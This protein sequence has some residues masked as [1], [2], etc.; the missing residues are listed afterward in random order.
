MISFLQNKILLFSGILLLTLFAVFSPAVSHSA[1][2]Q[3]YSEC[4]NNVIPGKIEYALCGEGATLKAAADACAAKGCTGLQF[5]CL[6]SSAGSCPTPPVDPTATLTKAAGG[7]VVQYVLPSVIKALIGIIQFL[8]SVL[9]WVVGIV[10]RLFDQAVAIALAGF[11]QLKFIELGWTIAR[12]VANI[13]FILILLVIAIATILR[14]ET[15]GIKQLLPRLVITALLINFSLVISFAVVDASNLLALQFIEPI[16][17]VS[18]KI[19]DV[20]NI[21]QIT[22]LNAGTSPRTEI[23]F[24][25]AVTNGFYDVLNKYNNSPVAN[26]SAATAMALGQAPNQFDPLIVDGLFQVIILILLLILIF[27]FIALGA[28]LIIRTIALMVIF[29]FAPIGFIAGILPQTKGYSTDWWRALFNWSFFFPASAF[30]MYLAIQYGKEISAIVRDSQ[31]LNT[32]ALFSYVSIAAI[33]LGS[34]LVA[35]KMGIYG[36]D[37]AINIGRKIQKSAQGYAGRGTK[38]LG[39]RA[40]GGVAQSVTKG[41]SSIPV[42]GGVLAKTPAAIVRADEKR[43][44]EKEKQYREIAKG[45]KT[46][47]RAALQGTALP[48]NK[49]L[50]RRLAVEEGKADALDTADLRRDHAKYI[51]TGNTKA[52]KNIEKVLPELAATRGATP[53]E[54]ELNLNQAVSN[55]TVKD[56]QDNLREDSLAN[57]KVQNALLLAAKSNVLEAGLDEFGKKFGD[58][59]ESAYT[60]LKSITPPPGTSQELHAYDKLSRSTAKFFVVSPGAQILNSKISHEIASSAKTRGHNFNP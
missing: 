5:Q 22:A 14:V 44:S 13:F 15:Y 59:L 50:I 54:Q 43:K 52:I 53:Q 3:F 57:E 39:L 51:T 11:G 56:I 48:G 12:D 55:L 16:Y 38:N 9:V 27:V 18:N 40:T 21:S 46:A 35:K 47:V 10:A 1:D 36:A 26:P 25:D 30:M 49:E 6:G 23:E 32:A 37:A 19:A 31:T 60:R 7:A 41:V 24:T 34:I 28:L 8:N 2:A 29:V 17:P 45:S 4:I 20:M 33:L 42:I 58:A